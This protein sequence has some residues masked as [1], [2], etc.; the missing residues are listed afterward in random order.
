MP[1]FFSF[2]KGR[3]TNI[4]KQFR[5]LRFLSKTICYHLIQE[6]LVMWF[7]EG[8]CLSGCAPCFWTHSE[9]RSQPVDFIENMASPRMTALSLTPCGSSRP[10]Q[11]RYYPFCFWR[12]DVQA[13]ASTFSCCHLARCLPYSNNKSHLQGSIPV[14]LQDWKSLRGHINLCCFV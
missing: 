5:P 12:L 10:S 11:K 4:Y 13:L 6:F 7:M 2:L 9:S 1:F 14:P 3:I 8:V